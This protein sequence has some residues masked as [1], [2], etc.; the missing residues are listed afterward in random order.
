MTKVMGYKYTKNRHD[1]LSAFFIPH[2][3][4]T[5]MSLADYTSLFG[6]TGSRDRIFFAD[7]QL[8]IGNTSPAPWYGQRK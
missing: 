3:F 8:P 1:L 2:F 4:I 5:E 6:N 7:L